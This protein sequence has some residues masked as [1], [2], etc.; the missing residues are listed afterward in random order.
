[1]HGRSLAELAIR[2][3][4]NAL[5]NISDGV[6]MK[7]KVQLESVEGTP[8][9]IRID[10][11]II[12][13]LVREVENAFDDRLA[14]ARRSAVLEA[15]TEDAVLSEML[16]NRAR[17]RHMLGEDLSIRVV[18]ETET[19]S[20]E[21]DSCGDVLKVDPFISARITRVDLVGYQV[22]HG[23]GYVQ[24]LPDRIPLKQL[25]YW[26]WHAGEECYVPAAEPD[27]PVSKSAEQARRAPA[28]DQS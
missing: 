27:A 4:V 28:A 15:P 5:A 8:V 1:V 3:S 12:A 23:R 14:K 11:A 24:P 26:R 9:S 19:G 20:F 21:V 18:I 17:L 13:R 10:R 2:E 16:L 7:F 6:A 25:G 22:R